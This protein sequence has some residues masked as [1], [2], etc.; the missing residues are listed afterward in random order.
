MFTGQQG[1][2]SYFSFS[3][4]LYL[5]MN[6]IKAFTHNYAGLATELETRCRVCAYNPNVQHETN[7]GKI[8]KFKALWD[9]GAMASVI[10]TNVVYNLER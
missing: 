7:P 4:C 2:Y 6:K 10:S 5:I 8:I 3:R 1:L 9:T